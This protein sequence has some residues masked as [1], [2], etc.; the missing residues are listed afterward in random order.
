MRPFVLAGAEFRGPGPVSRAPRRRAKRWQA[1][2]ICHVSFVRAGAVPRAPRCVKRWQARHMR[3]G[4]LDR[5]RA[6]LTPTLALTHIHAI[7]HSCAFTH[8]FFSLA[9][10]FTIPVHGIGRLLGPQCVKHARATW[11]AAQPRRAPGPNQAACPRLRLAAP[12][13]AGNRPTASRPRRAATRNPAAPTTGVPTRSG[14]QQLAAPSAR[15]GSAVA[16]GRGRGRAP[17]APIVRRPPQPGRRGVA[18][19]DRLVRGSAVVCAAS[20]RRWQPHPDLRS[21]SAGVRLRAA[22]KP[23]SH[24]SRVPRRAETRHK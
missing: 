4:A 6:R 7:T 10:V 20:R 11:T 15:A 13:R 19:P 8:I 17:L 22:A 14:Q 23:G 12:A 9:S 1:R 3:L 5:C 21:R 2:H 24:R 16:R 18:G